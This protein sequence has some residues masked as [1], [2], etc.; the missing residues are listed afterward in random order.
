[1]IREMVEDDVAALKAIHAKSGFDYVFPDLCD[2][3]FLVS[4]VVENEGCV[5]QGIAAKIELTVCLWVD[6]SKGT[7]EQRW[8]WLR[9]LI[10]ET[11]QAAWL[12]GVDTI[13]C[14]VP[15]EIADSFEKRLKAVGM[16]RDRPWPKFSFNLLDYIPVVRVES[17]E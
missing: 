15:P 1:M 10:E 6:H 16:S 5:V 9:E 4:K 3:L 11:K 7:P 2:P 8:Q 17:A 14:V 12:R 13:T